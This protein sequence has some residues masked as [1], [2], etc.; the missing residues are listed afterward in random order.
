MAWG[1]NPMIYILG[2]IL[3]IVLFFGLLMFSSSGF[4]QIILTSLGGK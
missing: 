2:I 3:F 4:K 1:E